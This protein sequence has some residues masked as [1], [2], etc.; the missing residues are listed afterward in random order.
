MRKYCPWLRRS[1]W[2]PFQLGDG[3]CQVRHAKNIEMSNL[4]LTLEDMDFRP[5]FVFDDVHGLHLQDT[6][7]PI[8]MNQ[9]VILKNVTGEQFDNASSNQV[10]RLTS[11]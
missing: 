11:Q 7:L 9:Q 10:R 2:N 8:G 1:Q 3:G 6:N 4:T 5:G